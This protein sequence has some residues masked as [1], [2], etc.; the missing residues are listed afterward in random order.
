MGGG[1]G[2]G[3]GCGAGRDGRKRFKIPSSP[4]PEISPCAGA[5]NKTVVKNEKTYKNWDRE[6]RIF[7]ESIL[8]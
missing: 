3:G 8:L 5:R 4:L 6:K 1:G 7:F 2:G